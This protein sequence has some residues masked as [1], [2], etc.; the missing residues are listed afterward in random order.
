MDTRPN[1]YHTVIAGKPHLQWIFSEKRIAY[2][3]SDDG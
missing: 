1:G 3:L 2:N